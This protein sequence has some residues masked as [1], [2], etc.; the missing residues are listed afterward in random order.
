M[1]RTKSYH[2]PDLTVHTG[3]EKAPKRELQ[4]ELWS[5]PGSST[6]A[7][8]KSKATTL[9]QRTCR[10]T[11]PCLLS[12]LVKMSLGNSWRAA[13]VGRGER[14]LRCLISSSH[15]AQPCQRLCLPSLGLSSPCPREPA[16]PKSSLCP[17]GSLCPVL[18]GQHHPAPKVHCAPEIHCVLSSWPA[19]ACDPQ[20]PKEGQ[21][22]PMSPAQLPAGGSRAAQS[23]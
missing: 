13:K 6:A 22:S 15:P 3:D 7:G 20:M 19:P 23:R 18:L 14:K 17:K 2:I 21:T 11:A 10:T 4:S 5:T 16:R 1:P 12:S 8:E 9:T